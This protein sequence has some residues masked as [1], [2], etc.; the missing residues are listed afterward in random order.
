MRIKRTFAEERLLEG[1]LVEAWRSGR[2]LVVKGTALSWAL[3]VS[4]HARVPRDVFI[5]KVMAV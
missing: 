5:G 4:A 2:G 3:Y 1:G